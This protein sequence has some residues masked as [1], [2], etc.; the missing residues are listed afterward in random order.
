MKVK[1]NFYCVGAQKAGTTALFA[2]LKQHKD[3]Y[4]PDIKEDHFFDIDEKFEKGLDWYISTYF[5]DVTNQ[6]LIG[7]ITPCY[8]YF[9]YCAKRMADC[10][11]DEIKIIIILRNPVDRA[12]SQYL[13]SQRRGYEKLSFLK[14]IEIE[15]D[16]ISAGQLAAERY[17]Y[18]SRG[19]YNEQIENYYKF[20]K[21]NNI[22]ILIYEDFFNDNLNNNMKDL[23]HFLNVEQIEI[24]EIG[25]KNQSS[26][27]RSDFLRD[28][29]FKENIIK[30][31]AKVLVFNPSIRAKIRDTFERIN[32]R[33]EKSELTINT[34]K[35]L[36][37]EFFLEDIEKL[38]INFKLKLDKWKHI[39]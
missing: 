21:P 27:A 15:K 14:A 5:N 3:I 33:P 17:S 1:P 16:R 32:T 22:K 11:G 31:L 36:L 4:L 8:L 30:K 2:G 7:A 6:K 20:F 26:V 19:L 28:V 34:R 24:T 12:Y 13:M 37:E 18:I 23:F 35:K 9:N 29:V 10:F 39:K 38:E 25:R